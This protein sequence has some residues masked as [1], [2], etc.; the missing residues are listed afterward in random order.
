[1]VYYVRSE[2]S[3]G[4]VGSG[5]VRQEGVEGRDQV[6]GFYVDEECRTLGGTATIYTEVGAGAGSEEQ[7]AQEAEYPEKGHLD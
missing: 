5:A 4:K 1:M 2:G 6:V 3:A 7:E